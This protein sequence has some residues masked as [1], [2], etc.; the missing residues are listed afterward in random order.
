[1]NGTPMFLIDEVDDLNLWMFAWYVG[2]VLRRADVL[3]PRSMM[4]GRPDAEAI[5]GSSI[6][7]T[8]KRHG[9][10]IPEPE[11]RGPEIPKN[12]SINVLLVDDGAVLPVEADRLEVLRQLAD[13]R[14]KRE[15]ALKVLNDVPE[16]LIRTFS[17]VFG[18]FLVAYTR[19]CRER[20]GQTN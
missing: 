18:D 16:T 5:V 10:E 9:L 14:F 1:M 7:S 17:L 20:A 15:D 6:R 12:S 19:Y 13:D 3:V 4:N 8:L 11:R 2:R